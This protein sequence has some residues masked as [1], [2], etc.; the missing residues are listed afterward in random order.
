MKNTNNFKYRYDEVEGIFIRDSEISVNWFISEVL[1]EEKLRITKI[2]N[3]DVFKLL[4]LLDKSDLRMPDGKH[5]LFW[6]YGSKPCFNG[7]L[8]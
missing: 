2:S 8:R 1:K 3:E 7:F 4:Q 6:L 5:S